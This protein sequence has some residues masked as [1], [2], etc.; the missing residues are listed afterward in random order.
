MSPKAKALEAPGDLPGS[1]APAGKEKACERIFKAACDLFYRQGIRAVGVETIAEEAHATKMSLYR[2]YPSKDELVAEYLR[3]HS[4]SIW[5][6]WDALLEQHPGDPRGRLSALFAELNRMINDPNSRGCA[7]ANA[8]V[9]LRDPNHPG[10]KIVE[11]HKAEM[12]SR[13]LRLCSDLGVRDPSA[14][15]DGLFLLMEGAFSSTQTLGCSGPGCSVARAADALIE[16][17]AP[18]SRAR[19]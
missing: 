4:E 1:P 12:R 2:T 9:E 15:A 7:M 14:L 5:Q 11:G 10:R 13:L 3:R 16:A 17:H 18:K 19:A 8:A 6:K